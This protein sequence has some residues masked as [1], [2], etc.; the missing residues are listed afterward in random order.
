MNKKQE[1][2]VVDL[3]RKEKKVIKNNGIEIEVEE[4]DINDLDKKTQKLLKKLVDK[5]KGDKKM[6]REN[7]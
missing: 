6:W 4:I 2:A 7:E 1:K 3:L 5:L